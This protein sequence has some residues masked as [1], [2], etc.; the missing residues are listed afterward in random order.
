MIDE[1]DDW[2]SRTPLAHPLLPWHLAPAWVLNSLLVLL[3]ATGAIKLD[4]A[5]VDASE[6][7]VALAVGNVL[8]VLFFFLAYFA[9]RVDQRHFTPAA[10]V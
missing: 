6:L 2:L 4:R 5:D 10:F 1:H 7:L 3:L 8:S 9:T